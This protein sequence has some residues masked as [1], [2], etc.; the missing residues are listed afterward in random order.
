MF[1]KAFDVLADTAVAVVDRATGDHNVCSSPDDALYVRDAHP[2]IHLDFTVGVQA[3]TEVLEA[4]DAVETTLDER[5]TTESGIDTHD[6]RQV[7]QWEC[8]FKDVEWCQGIDSQTCFQATTLDGL[9][10]TV[11][12]LGSFSMDCDVIGSCRFEIGKV[13]L[14][15]RDHQVDIEREICASSARFHNAGSQGDVR[16]EVAIHY[17]DVK[18]VGTRLFRGSRFIA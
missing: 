2:A 10:G 9:K 16:H 13:A 5:L 15:K 6:E 11:M 7:D 3:R 4:G 8:L 17:V 12:V 14:W 18:I 1:S